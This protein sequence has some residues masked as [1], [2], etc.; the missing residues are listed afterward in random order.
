MRIHYCSSCEGNGTIPGIGN[1]QIECQ[2]C[3]GIGSISVQSSPENQMKD[4][5]AE[6][7]ALYL[8]RRK[9]RGMIETGFEAY[10]QAR[11]WSWLRQKYICDT[12]DGS[13]MVDSGGQTPWGEWAMKPCP[14]CGHGN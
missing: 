1:R 13:G 6:F 5:S 7:I 2:D 10:V 3:L 4:T 8:G 12:C 11:C 9:A 14:E